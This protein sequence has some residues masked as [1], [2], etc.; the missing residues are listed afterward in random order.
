M[1]GSETHRCD[2]GGQRVQAEIVSE[3]YVSEVFPTSFIYFF[4]VA[5]IYFGVA[6]I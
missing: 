4:G 2:M 1:R 6:L 3:V 5:F